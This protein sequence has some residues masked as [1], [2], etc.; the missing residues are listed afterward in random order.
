MTVA[1]RYSLLKIPATISKYSQ[2]TMTT[3][4]TTRTTSPS[5]WHRS[6]Q[7]LP[8]NPAKEVDQKVKLRGY[9]NVYLS[10]IGSTFKVGKDKVLMWENS[11][12]K[13]K[14]YKLQVEVLPHSHFGETTS[15]PLTLFVQ[16]TMSMGSTPVDRVS[17]LSRSIPPRD[18][19]I[20]N[21]HV[22]PIPLTQ[23]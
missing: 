11:Q 10:Q 16:A 19:I 15:Q 12:L 13:V 20:L 9:I 22:I 7:R 17:N 1:P 14:L 6:Q 23:I 3:T 5:N 2:A 18:D 21:T 4:T 8:Q